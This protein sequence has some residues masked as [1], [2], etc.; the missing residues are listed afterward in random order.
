MPGKEMIAEF[1]ATTH[2]ADDLLLPAPTSPPLPTQ[3][4]VE[5][6]EPAGRPDIPVWASVAAGDGD[7]EMILVDSPIDYVRRSEKMLTVKSP[8]AFY[9]VG[10]SMEPRFSAGDQV[11]INPSQ[12]VK[13]GDDCVFIH[14]ASD[15]TMYGLVKRLLRNLADHYRV[16]QFN[17][18]K[19]LDLSKRKWSKAYRVAE[20]RHRG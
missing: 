19:E 9:I 3:P 18:A 1:S 16:R 4:I 14:T 7:G 6:P 8:F 2:L 13:V 17:P 15:G 10:D 11:V 12:P 5:V 20:T